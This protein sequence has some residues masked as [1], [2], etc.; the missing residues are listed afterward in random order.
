MQRHGIYEYVSEKYDN[1]GPL[2]FEGL[3]KLVPYR[4]L[5][6]KHFKNLP[7]TVS[8]ICGVSDLGIRD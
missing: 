3:L 7:T 5:K 2:I 1:L 8:G 6:G 4:T